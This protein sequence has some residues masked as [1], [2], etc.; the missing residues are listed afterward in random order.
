M[1]HCECLGD[2]ALYSDAMSTMP[3]VA[4]IFQMKY[5]T[6]NQLTCARYKAYQELGEGNVPADLY[7]HEHA[8]LKE[9]LA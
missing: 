8:K 2:C 9:L 7:P 4:S 6:G 5:C 3:G 1:P